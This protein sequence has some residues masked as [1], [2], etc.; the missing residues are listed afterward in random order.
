M[1][2]FDKYI[3]DQF[4][5]PDDYSAGRS[6]NW[7]RLAKRLEAE[8]RARPFRFLMRRSRWSRW[9]VAASIIGLLALNGWAMWQWQ[10][11]IRENTAIRKRHLETTAA[12]QPK[13]GANANGATTA[14]ST[15]AQEM[16]ANA[17]S[18]PNNNTADLNKATLSELGKEKVDLST[19]QSAWEMAAPSA[20]TGLT[21]DANASNPRLT[22]NKIGWR[23]EATNTRLSTAQTQ[24]REQTKLGQDKSNTNLTNSSSKTNPVST[25]HFPLPTNEA[26]KLAANELTAAVERVRKDK[27]L[28]TPFAPLTSAADVTTRTVATLAKLPRLKHL[29]NEGWATTTPTPAVIKKH[30]TWLPGVGLGAVAFVGQHAPKPTGVELMKGRGLVASFSPIKRLALQ[31]AVHWV[32]NEFEVPRQLPSHFPDPKR[33]SIPA[34]EDVKQIEGDMHR[35][36]ISVGAKYALTTHTWVRPVVSIGHTWQYLRPEMTIFKFKDRTTGEEKQI[37]SLSEPQRREGIW[38]GGIGLEKDVREWTFTLG[39]S[40]LKDAGKGE[41][42]PGIA[43]L[44][45]GLRYNIF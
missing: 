13:K 19:K 1:S 7:E 11:A 23:N 28:H 20:S 22:K 17:A 25:E 14:P 33:P 4:D 34:K 42:M 43:T 37:N 44:Q 18:A 8:E 31:T 40:W 29:V 36:W 27:A 6:A 16:A 24:D 32:E 9:A 30:R 39:A 45:A 5:D 35:R 3:R 26:E 2:D 38:Y 12:S 15:T 10:Q 41:Q 21:S